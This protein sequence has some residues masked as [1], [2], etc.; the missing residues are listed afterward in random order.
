MNN[1]PTNYE[2]QHDA[3]FGREER[4]RKFHRACWRVENLPPIVEVPSQ[5]V[6][7]TQ[8]EYADVN[9]AQ[10]DQDAINRI[11][12]QSAGFVGDFD[13]NIKAEPDVDQLRPYIESLYDNGTLGNN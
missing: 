4:R 12:R 6:E 7:A 9:R 10:L 1:T 11:M 2:S 13:P 5:R 3:E 8:A